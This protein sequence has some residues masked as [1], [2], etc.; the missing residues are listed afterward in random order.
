MC[1]HPCFHHFCL[2]PKNL[3]LLVLLIKNW[4]NDPTI[5]FEAK[6]RLLKNVDEFGE[7]DE[8]ILDLLDAKFPNEVEDLYLHVFT[9]FEH[10]HLHAFT[11]PYTYTFRVC[12]LHLH[13][14]LDLDLSSM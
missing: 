3:D 9:W 14:L 11:W 8:N 10:L 13:L 7:V 5:G 4:P 2:G 6:G 1:F 12:Q